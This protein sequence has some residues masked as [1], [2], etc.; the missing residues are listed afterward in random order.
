MK[1]SFIDY[2]WDALGVIGAFVVCAVIASP[3]DWVEYPGISTERFTS[4][5][6]VRQTCEL[7]T[8]ITLTAPD[9]RHVT[10]AIAQIVSVTELRP[11]DSFYPY[12][13]HAIISE[14]SGKDQAVRESR[15]QIEAM[16]ATPTCMASIP[17]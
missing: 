10:I 1:K 9:G 15:S 14:T 3:F 17:L 2:V 7:P 16:E 4:D 5:H 13:A 12:S 11:R 6:E 8:H